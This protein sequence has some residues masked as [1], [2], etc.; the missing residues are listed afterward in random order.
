MVGDRGRDGCIARGR[1]CMKIF[2][3]VPT[4]RSFETFLSEFAEFAAQRG[5][6]IKIAFAGANKHPRCLARGWSL[7]GDPEI[8]FPRGANFFGH[9]KAAL[10][11][12]RA[13]DGFRPEILSIHFSAASF[14]CALARRTSWRTLATIQGVNYVQQ[15]GWRRIMMQRVEM[16]AYRRM[17]EVWVL[18]RDDAANLRRDGLQSQVRLQESLGFG[19]RLDIFD[20]L[21]IPRGDVLHARSD[22]GVRPGEIVFAF[23]GRQTAFKGFGIAVRA[24]LSFHRDFPDS[25]LVL[26]GGRDYLHG[27]GLS[28]RDRSA[29]KACESI[30]DMGWRSDVSAI[31]A[32]VD[33][34][35]FPSQREGIP[36]NLMEALAMGVPC[37]AYDCRGSRD[38]V[39]HGV[40]GKIVKVCSAD[41]FASTMM[42]LAMD[43]GERMMLSANAI[44]DRQRFDRNRFVIEHLRNLERLS[45]KART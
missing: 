21:K 28:S 42:E 38:V 20:R 2:V 10:S 29:L 23:I 12:R 30:V 18:T 16:W 15:R 9:L 40:D 25:R 39:R 33:I 4:A 24:F 31:L 14:T 32:N 35:L 13:V 17:S 27:Q 44:R 11:L 43:P 26:V 5:H 36:V 45:A 3:C 6:V 41:A 19:C 8:N 34:V 1:Q 22:M 37:I 7:V